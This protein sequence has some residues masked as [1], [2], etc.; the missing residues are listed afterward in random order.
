VKKVISICDTCGQQ[1]DVHTCGE[2]RR[3]ICDKCS[4][5]LGYTLRVCLDHIQNSNIPVDHF[6]RLYGETN[7]ID[8]AFDQMLGFR[9]DQWMLVYGTDDGEISVS[10]HDTEDDA[11]S[12]IKSDAFDP[13][14]GWRL[15]KVYHNSEFYRMDAIIQI[16]LTPIVWRTT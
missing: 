3:D 5:K 14:G 8:R 15:D 16:K 4:V 9:Q 2:C 12:Y 13:E 10:I 6:K 11:S 1:A 7:Y